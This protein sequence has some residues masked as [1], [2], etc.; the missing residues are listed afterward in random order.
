MKKLSLS[1][2][3]LSVSL[4]AGCASDT[5]S[6]E[7]EEVSDDVIE[8]VNLIEN[9]DDTILDFSSDAEQ[10]SEEEIERI[11][12]AAVKAP[13]GLNFQPYW[14]T[15]ITDY[16]K[17]MELA[18]TPETRPEEGTVM[19]IYSTPVDESPS[20]IDV[21]ISYGYMKVQADLEG[22]GSHIYGQPAR[23]LRDDGN[24][25]DFGIPEGYEPV[26]LVIVGK[27]DEVDGKTSATPGEREQKWNFSE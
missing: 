15:V 24:P 8:T 23:I 12:E 13:S 4:L 7:T 25:Q 26:E 18:L 2:L 19:F 1:T 22:Y 21:G 11:L 3:F 27:A 10:P 20:L 6:E 16:E 17:Q 14:I 5:A 9:M